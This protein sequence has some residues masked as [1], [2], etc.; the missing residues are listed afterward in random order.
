MPTSPSK[1]W[2]PH[3]YS[4]RSGYPTSSL[5]K[6]WIPHLLY[7]LRW[8]PHLYSLSLSLSGVDTPLLTLIRDGYPSSYILQGVDTPLLVRLRGGYPTSPTTK[9]DT[10]PLLSA[11]SV[12]ALYTRLPPVIRLQVNRCTLY[13]SRKCCIAGMLY[14]FNKQG[15][16]Y[17]YIY[18]LQGE[19]ARSSNTVYVLLGGVLGVFCLV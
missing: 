1:Q 11:Y 6:R 2:I 19:L 16:I 15:E 18:S 17:I 10:P 7:R 14:V 12:Y 4:A 3:S 9:M 5:Y 8:I 13:R